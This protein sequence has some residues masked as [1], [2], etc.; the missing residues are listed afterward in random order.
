[1]TDDTDQKIL[2]LLKQDSRI[3]NADL[4]EQVGLSSSSCWRRV[5]ALED[6]GAI[7]NYSVVLDDEKIGLGFQVLV[8]V[9][10]TRHDPEQLQDFISAVGRKQE[11]RDCYATTGQSD[12]H[13][14][15]CC[16]D[17]NAYNRFLENFLFRL[18]AVASAQSNVVLR[19]V[20]HQ[21]KVVKPK[22]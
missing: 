7:R 4:A 8:H 10:L 15:V 13:L 5:R 20:K 3:S 17:L 14:F 6:S 19:A 21:D 9:Q 2:Q 22:R 11:V 18:P 1:M 12:Y 16:S